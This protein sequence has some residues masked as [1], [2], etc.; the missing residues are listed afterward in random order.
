VEGEKPSKRR[1]RILLDSGFEKPA[2]DLPVLG[3]KGFDVFREKSGIRR[4]LL[5]RRLRLAFSEAD[6][7][8]KEITKNFIGLERFKNAQSVALYFPIKNEVMTEGIFESARELCKQIYFPRVDGPLLE[9]GMVNNLS[10]L[11]PGRFGIPEP[12]RDAAKVEIA[13][14]D[15]IIIPG[16]AFD[17]FGR[18]IGYGKGYYDRALIKIDKKRRIGLAYNFQIVDSIPMEVGGDEVG[19]I[20]T[21]LGLILPKRRRTC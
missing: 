20:V 16:V 8:S 19:L 10:E 21:E 17:R 11:K 9:F 18:R 1:S 2:S 5:K 12:N 7:I 6:K 3:E 4:D 15:L 13:D 14:I